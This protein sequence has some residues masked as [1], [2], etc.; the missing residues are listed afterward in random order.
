MRLDRDKTFYPTSVG[1]D[2]MFFPVSLLC[3]AVGLSWR[4]TRRHL[5]PNHKELPFCV[6]AFQ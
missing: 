4:W 6:A 3:V 2:V 1:V 5:H